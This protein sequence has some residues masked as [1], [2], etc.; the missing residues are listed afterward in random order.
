MPLSLSLKWHYL[1]P[2]VQI[3]LTSARSALAMREKR[4]GCNVA[5]S[6]ALLVSLKFGAASS[7]SVAL[8][9]EPH[10]FLKSSALLIRTSKIDFDQMDGLH[11]GPQS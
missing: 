5:F 1:Q 11:P 3:V 8:S 6:L 9:K 7:F 2:W 10:S 4:H